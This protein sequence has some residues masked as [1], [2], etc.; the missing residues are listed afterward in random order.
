LRLERREG[1]IYA[2]ISHDGRNWAAFL[3][4]EVR[5]TDELKVGVAA[6]N[7]SAKPFTAVLVDLA[8]F[9]RRPDEL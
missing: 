3:T 6:I 4:L 9:P 8:G 5:L 7:S 2:S 1:V